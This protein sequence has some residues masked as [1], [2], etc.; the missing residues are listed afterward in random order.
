MRKSTLDS[1][2]SRQKVYDFIRK[3]RV[4][5]G[6]WAMVNL[7]ERRYYEYKAAHQDFR[8][9]VNHVLEMVASQ[10]PLH[11]DLALIKAGREK[12]SQWFLGG[13]KTTRKT[14]RYKAIP[15]LDNDGSPRRDKAGKQLVDWEPVELLLSEYDNGIS[16]RAFDRVFPPAT[17][18]QES[19]MLV[20]GNIVKELQIDN[21]LNEE[22]RQL[23]LFW[24]SSFQEKAVSELL[25]LGL[26]TSK[27]S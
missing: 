11:E 3:T 23:I 7:Q 1:D 12:F 21:D 5:S 16:D 18:T 25:M 24:L 6:C 22:Q 4:E 2:T 15:I 8:E 9:E 14:I 26:S 20:I 10:R 19:L 17:F 27:I 13:C